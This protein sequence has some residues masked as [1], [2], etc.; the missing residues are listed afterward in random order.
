MGGTSLTD[1]CGK[2]SSA[3]A[4]EQVSPRPAG[5]G[6]RPPLPSPGRSPAPPPA[7][8]GRGGAGLAPANVCV[9]GHT[10]TLDMYAVIKV[11][12]PLEQE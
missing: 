2:N 11:E 1:E 4:G 10:F 7:E 12:P 8:G 9:V 5:G 3:G 6:S